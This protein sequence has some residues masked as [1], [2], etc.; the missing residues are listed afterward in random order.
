MMEKRG[1]CVSECVFKRER[2]DRVRMR[3]PTVMCPH[4]SDTTMWHSSVGLLREKERE[5][6]EGERERSTNNAH[7]VLW[8]SSW[9][10]VQW[11]KGDPFRPGR[12]ASH[13]PAAF[14]R[15]EVDGWSVF[16]L[17]KYCDTA[18]M[19]EKSVPTLQ[20][21][22]R[23]RRGATDN[24]RVAI[25]QTSRGRSFRDGDTQRPLFLGSAEVRLS[26]TLEEGISFSRRNIKRTETPLH[27]R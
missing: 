26:R 13:Y 23:F 11:P 5:G 7:W 12:G 19:E 14:I 17:V 20:N 24:Q 25:I 9:W 3:P 27:A 16:I 10:D 2:M 4:S 15:L 8:G 21:Q 22:S 18:K 1:V 6:R